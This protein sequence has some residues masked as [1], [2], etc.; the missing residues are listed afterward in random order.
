GEYLSR[1]LRKSSGPLALLPSHRSAEASIATPPSPPCFRRQEPSASKFSSEKPMGSISLWQLAQGSILRCSV[2]CSRSVMILSDSPLVSSSGGTFGG[3]SGGGVPRMFSKIHAPRFT[4][5][6]RKFCCHVM[7]RKL[8]CPSNPRR[9]AYCG[10][11][12]TRRIRDP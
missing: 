7:E 2:I 4:G 5:D 6:V 3:G 9:Y 11:S 8:P 1:T 10:P 12:C